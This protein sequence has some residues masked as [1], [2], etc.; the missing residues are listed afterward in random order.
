MDKII[1][2]LGLY[3]ILIMVVFIILL[4]VG[5]PDQLIFMFSGILV[6]AGCSLGLVLA[7]SDC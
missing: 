4:L 6:G 5:V 3:I 2:A 1:T 7:G